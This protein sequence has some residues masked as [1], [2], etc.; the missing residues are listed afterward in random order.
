MSAFAGSR[1]ALERLDV[2]AGPSRW[3]DSLTRLRDDLELDPNG[4]VLST[5]DDDPWVRAA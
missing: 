4:T 5:W 3:L 2:D 1:P